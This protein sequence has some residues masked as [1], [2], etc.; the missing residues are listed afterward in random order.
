MDPSV[1]DTIPQSSRT[2]LIGRRM[3]QFDALADHLQKLH[4]RHLKMTSVGVLCFLCGFE[5]FAHW[6]EGQ[7]WVLLVAFGFLGAAFAVV[8]LMRSRT[9]QLAY[10]S[11][12]TIAEILRTWFF[13]DASGVA[14]PPTGEWVPRR[15]LVPMGEIIKIRD[16]I[17][18]EAGDKQN[19]EIPEAIVRESW[20]E[21]QKRFFRRRTGEA[22][23]AG[24]MWADLSSYGFVLAIFAMASLVVTSLSGNQH[25][26]WGRQLLVIAP[27]PPRRRCTMCRFYLERRGF[28]ANAQRYR[29]SHSIYEVPGDWIGMPK[30]VERRSRSAQRECRHGWYV[31]SYEREIHLPSG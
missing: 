8:F 28:K 22:D 9:V 23:R 30:S 1:W 20:F 26:V 15:Y 3:L 25:T 21:G 7:T 11:T 12:R 4:Y 13:M 27:L 31:A 10:L 14:F 18:I 17:S 6:F 24:R 5:L 2:R 16:H 29:H 19:F